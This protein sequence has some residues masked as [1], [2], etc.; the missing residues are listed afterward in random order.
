MRTKKSVDDTLV[1]KAIYFFSS[2]LHV[3]C[4]TRA[5]S[6]GWKDNLVG[7]KLKEKLLSGLSFTM[8]GS[9]YI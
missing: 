6:I 3:K 1:L 4:A 8:S 7:L 9:H 2:F 5:P